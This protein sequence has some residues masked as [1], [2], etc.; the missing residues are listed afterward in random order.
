MG[1]MCY[2]KKEES[3]GEEVAEVSRCARQPLFWGCSCNS[4]GVLNG[5]EQNG[6]LVSVFRCL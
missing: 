6:F 2:V 4:A 3:P 1:E 5:R